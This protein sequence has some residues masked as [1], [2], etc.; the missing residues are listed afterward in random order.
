MYPA[1]AFSLYDVRSN[2]I[3][4]TDGNILK[5]ERTAHCSA[6]V[7]LVCFVWR[8]YMYLRPIH[9]SSVTVVGGI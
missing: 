7:F 8:R 3:A 5:I 4:D 9:S 2:S 1:A 6:S